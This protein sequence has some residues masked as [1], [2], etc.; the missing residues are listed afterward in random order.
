VEIR[1]LKKT[2]KMVQKPFARQGDMMEEIGAA[3]A[4]R[5]NSDSTLKFEIKPGDNTADFAVESK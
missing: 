5:Y 3:V 2:G 4:P 1:A